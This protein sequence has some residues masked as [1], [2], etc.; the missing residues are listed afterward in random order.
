MKNHS[1]LR[2]FKWILGPCLLFFFKLRYEYR[3]G[4]DC[5][6]AFRPLMCERPQFSCGNG[7]VPL[8]VVFGWQPDGVDIETYRSSRRSG[9]CPGAESRGK[10]E[11]EANQALPSQSVAWGETPGTGRWLV[12]LPRYWFQTGMGGR[13][14]KASGADCL[15]CDRFIHGKSSPG[16]NET[17]LDR[18]CAI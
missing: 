12:R 9:G 2:C 13:P 14:N 6:D 17:T 15:D 4:S 8:R 11:L 7:D 3:L 10:L 18:R 5:N 1:K 16:L